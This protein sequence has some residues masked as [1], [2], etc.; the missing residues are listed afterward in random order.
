MRIR[1]PNISAVWN[2]YAYNSYV[3]AGIRISNLQ[4]ARIMEKREEIAMKLH[5]IGRRKGRK[6]GRK[7]GRKNERRTRKD[8]RFQFTCMCLLQ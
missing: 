7:E 4:Y 3:N 5:K 8:I 6:E 1:K 2:R